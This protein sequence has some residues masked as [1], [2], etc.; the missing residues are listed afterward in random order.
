MDLSDNKVYLIL[1]YLI[2]C[3]AM[4]KYNGAQIYL[5]QNND[6]VNNSL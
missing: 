1:S 5:V 6:T 2:I 3:V 4:L